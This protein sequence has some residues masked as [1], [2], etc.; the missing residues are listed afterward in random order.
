MSNGIEGLLF[1][2]IGGGIVTFGLR[3]FE[4]VWIEGRL[5]ESIDARKK[6][7]KYA[8][9]LWLACNDLEWRFNNILEKINKNDVESLKW[10]PGTNVEL[11]W[12]V[13]DGY[14][15][16]STA[17][18]IANVSAWIR[19]LERDVVF[20][21]FKTESA[22]E[23]FFIL[24]NSL[25]VNLS[26]DSILWFHYFNG[27]GDYLIQNDVPISIAEFSNKLLTDKNYRAYYSQLYRFLQS[28]TED[29]KEE[30]IKKAIKDLGAIKRLLRDN[31]AV[32]NISKE[33]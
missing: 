32:P 18:L 25:K 2:A 11:D 5:A 27:I 29:N 17:Y 31:G 21:R 33:P 15:I 14:Y 1:G 13:M 28:L 16:T 26:T 4:K 3:A 6:M 19:L 30:F 22:T 7:M 12:Y 8:K 23:Q 9:P 24:V 10:Y 20:L